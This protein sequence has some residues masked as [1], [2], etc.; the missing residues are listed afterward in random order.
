M[1]AEHYDAVSALWQATEGLGDTETREEFLPLPV[2]QPGYQ[3][4]CFS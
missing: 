1:H 2:P 4:G 3:L